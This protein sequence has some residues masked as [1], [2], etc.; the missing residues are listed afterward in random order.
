MTKC[1]MGLAPDLQLLISYELHGVGRGRGHLQRQPEALERRGRRRPNVEFVEKNSVAAIGRRNHPLHHQALNFPGFQGLE[2]ATV[3]HSRLFAADRLE[4]GNLPKKA[5]SD[6]S[7]KATKMY[8]KEK[9][10]ATEKEPPDR[11]NMTLEMD[12][13]TF[14]QKSNIALIC[15][16]RFH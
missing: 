11:Q 14:A 12:F 15:R 2:L 8:H 3:D 5:K 9:M 6:E 1:F 7:F 4:R 10:A 13:L 16:K